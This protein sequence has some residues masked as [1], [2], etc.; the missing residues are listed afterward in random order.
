MLYF[1]ADDGTSGYELRKT[2]GTSVGTVRVK[3]IGPGASGSTP[4]DF[5]VVGSTLYF[6]ADDGASGAELWKTDGTATST[7]LVKDIAWGPE[8]SDPESL[9]TVGST[10]YFSADDGTFGRELWK[11]DGTSAGT[12]RISFRVS[13]GPMTAVGSTL[14]F[15]ADDYGFGRELWK[16][17][18]AATPPAAPT[19]LVGT[20]GNGRV[21]LKWKA[22]KSSGGSAITDYV[23][24]YKTA[25]ATSWT[26][27]QDGTSTATSATVERL[28]NGTKYVFRVS[29]KNAAGMSAFSAIVSVKPA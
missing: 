27:Y 9:K 24:Q 5:T 18:T 6:R 29:A 7:V 28:K 22:P 14:Y 10:L 12:S 26:T 8:A 23:I 20:P 17:E 13:A 16:L 11:T 3:D 1:R 21:S 2:D 19:S 15:V 4:R 25:L